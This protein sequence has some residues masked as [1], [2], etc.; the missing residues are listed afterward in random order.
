MRLPVLFLIAAGA[1]LCQSALSQTFE[2]A[3]VHLSPPA[4]Q[5]KDSKHPTVAGFRDSARHL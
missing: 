4:D 2:A 3:D 5:V 1:A